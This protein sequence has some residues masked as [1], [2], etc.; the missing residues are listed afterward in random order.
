V[1]T[2]LQNAHLGHVKTAYGKAS[3]SYTMVSDPTVAAA[4]D[5]CAS[6]QAGAA[7][8]RYDG[9][10]ST[11]AKYFSRIRCSCQAAGRL[12]SSQRWLRRRT[13]AMPSL[14]YWFSHDSGRSVVGGF[15]RHECERSRLAAASWPEV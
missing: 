4:S 3:L 9:V 11:G 2:T 15:A 7:A 8:D 5:R 13:C 1:P 6:C 10:F 12:P 14:R